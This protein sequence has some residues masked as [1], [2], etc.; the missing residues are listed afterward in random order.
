MISYRATLDVSPDLAATL[1]RLLAAHRWAIG[2]RARTRARTR[3]LTPWAQAVLL[4]RFFCDAT[5][6]AALAR[7]NAIALATAYRYLHESIDVIADQAPNLHQV[8]AD[9]DAEGLECLLLDGRADHHRPRQRAPSHGG[10]V[11]LGQAQA[12]RRQRP[13]PRQPRRL[14]AGVPPLA[15]AGP[16]PS[17]REQPM[18]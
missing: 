4:L 18:I 17:S 5:A 11:V 12:P 7:D 9:A 3:A 13:S 6:I 8:I 1:A 2:T 10:P 15:G 16:P 14:A